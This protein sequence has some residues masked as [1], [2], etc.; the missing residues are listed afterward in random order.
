MLPLV[1]NDMNHH[2]DEDLPT[3]TTTTLTTYAH[4]TPALICDDNTL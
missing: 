3:T 4:N 1:F 2:D